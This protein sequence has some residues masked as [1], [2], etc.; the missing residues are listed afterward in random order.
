[1]ALINTGLSL[2]IETTRYKEVVRYKE[3]EEIPK[4]VKEKEKWR[5]WAEEFKE[6]ND[7]IYYNDRRIIP[8]EEVNWIISMF[9][10]DLTMAY[11]NKG[12]VIW[13]IKERY[14]WPNLAKDVKEYVKTCYACQ[15]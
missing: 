12:E 10:D 7:Q 2:S 5:E 9:H 6:K 14:L 11:Q 8:K 1:M 3:T 4:R 13:R 15:Q